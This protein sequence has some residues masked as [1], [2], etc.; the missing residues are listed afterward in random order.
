MPAESAIAAPPAVP[1]E[2]KPSTP[3]PA[4]AP[5]TPP[6]ANEKPTAPVPANVS[7]INDDIDELAGI[8]KK[9]E[10]KKVEPKPE[11]TKPESGKPA[12]SAAKMG[13]KPDESKVPAKKG[14][15]A[16]LYEDGKAEI[17]R[18]N[19]E[20]HAERSK[21][22]TEDADKPKLLGAVETLKKENERLQETIRLSNFESSDDF[23]A[24]KDQYE[25]EYLTD[26]KRAESIALGFKVPTEDGVGR[27]F[28]ANEFW[29]I[30]QIQDSDDALTAA[31]KIFGEGSLRATNVIER[32]NEVLR[33][34]E[35]SQSLLKEAR[36]AGSK[37]SKEHQEKEDQ[38][39]A[40]ER[41]NSELAQRKA[42]EDFIRLKDERIASAPEYN[43]VEADDEEGSKLLKS[44]DA[45]AWLLF[46][47]PTPE[48]IES[49]NDGI[50]ETIVDGKLTPE[51]RLKLHASAFAAIRENPILR[52]KYGRVN[53]ENAELKEELKAYRETEPE[54]AGENG[55]QKAS[56]EL[57]IA[58]M[59]DAEATP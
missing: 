26:Y 4:P 56:G 32:R 46:G 49:L 47:N 58:Q 50:K 48:Q 2:S 45:Q 28:T 51:G 39:K 24:K 15:L 10:A 6:A 43:T 18:L 20:L 12:E 33:S 41:G 52:L 59:I 11:A 31:E 7:S 8:A 13:E 44:S 29:N 54:N 40:V 23:K 30:V 37:T 34:L 53:A 14:D 57:T 5:I 3:A 16:R 21:K 19:N 55:R 25:K 22:P 36:E 27:K 1:T 38:R 42:S 9:P 17:K 35:R